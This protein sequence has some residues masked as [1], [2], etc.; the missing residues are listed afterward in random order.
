VTVTVTV[1]VSAPGPVTEAV[2]LSATPLPYEPREHRDNAGRKR[3]DV[4]FVLGG[5]GA[6]K[7][8]DLDRGTDFRGFTAGYC[9][10]ASLVGPCDSRCAFCDVEARAFRGTRRFVTQFGVADLSVSHADEKL[11]RDVKNLEG[12]MRQ[13]AS[14]MGSGHA[15]HRADGVTTAS[16]RRVRA[17]VPSARRVRVSA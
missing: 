1:A 16:A 9:V 17:V 5:C 6:D 7:D 13:R 4:R 15:P 10:G 12:V 3:Y 8:G 14:T 11:A 2:T